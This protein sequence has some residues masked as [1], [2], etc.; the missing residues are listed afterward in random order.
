MLCL[1][2]WCKT[3]LRAAVCFSFFRNVRIIFITQQK[4]SNFFLLC[5]TLW[6]HR[7][8]HCLIC[9]GDSSSR[10]VFVILIYF[11]PI[12]WVSATNINNTTEA[13]NGRMFQSVLK[14]KKLKEKINGKVIAVM[15]PFKGYVFIVSIWFDNK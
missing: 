7:P 9:Y 14:R 3:R 11:S 6:F 8:S 12:A 10:Q 5:Y 13:I 4:P 15:A 2:T 1:D